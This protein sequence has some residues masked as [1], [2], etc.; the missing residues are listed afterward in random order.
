MSFGNEQ[1]DNG[2]LTLTFDRG[3]VT[4]A[5]FAPAHLDDRGVPVPATG[6]EARRIDTEWKHDRG[7]ADLAPRPPN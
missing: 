3:R 4:A 7:C 2:L 6:A 1:D 5:R